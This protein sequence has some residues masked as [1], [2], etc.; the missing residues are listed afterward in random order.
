MK[1][2]RPAIDDRPIRDLAHDVRLCPCNLVTDSGGFD[3][4]TA[5]TGCTTLLVDAFRAA[6]AGSSRARWLVRRGPETIEVRPPEPDE[7][8]F[9]GVTENQRVYDILHIARNRAGQ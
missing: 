1:E 4:D 5:V 8:D 7:I 3:A 9:L 6:R 2:Q